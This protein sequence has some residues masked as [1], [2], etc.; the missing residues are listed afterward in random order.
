MYFFP[1]WSWDPAD[2]LNMGWGDVLLLVVMFLGIGGLAV[3]FRC[4][5]A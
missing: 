5:F 4:C 1:E 3:E 2:C